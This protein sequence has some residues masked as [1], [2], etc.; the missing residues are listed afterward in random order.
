MVPYVMLLLFGAV[1]GSFLNVC[2][3]RLPRQE[4]VAWP[5]SHCPAC[6]Q[7]VAVYDNI[8]V[9]SYLILRGR[10]RSCHVPISIQYPLVEAANAIGYLLIFWVFDF[11]AEAWVYAALLSALIVITGTD[12]S[13]TMIPDAV[14]LPGIVVG[15]V[16]AAVILPIGLMDSLLGIALGG[17]ILWFL[18]WISPYVFGKEGMGGGDIKLMAM[19]GAFIGWQ[20]VLLA[21]MIGSFLGSVVGVGLIAAGITRR[22]QYIPFGPFLAVGSLLALLFHQPFLNWYWSLINL[23]Q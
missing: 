16:C 22:D 8:P 9:L 2:I 12:L 18:A 23:P 1:I 6:R 19:V 10:C 7:P 13:H 15:L 11:T 21:I 17:G 3:Y 5:A 20:P 4:S 14:T